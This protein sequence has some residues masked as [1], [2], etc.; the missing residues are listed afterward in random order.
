[1]FHL[2]LDLLAAS[3]TGSRNLTKRLRGVLVRTKIPQLMTIPD[4]GAMSAIAIVAL[5]PPTE[6]FAKG[7]DF[8]A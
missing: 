1:M 5:A 8:G 4:F 2:R 6:I 3:V 7:R